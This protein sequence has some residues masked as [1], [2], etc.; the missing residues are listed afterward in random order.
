MALFGR[1]ESL[2]V[3]P[4]GIT[5]AYRTHG[6]PGHPAVL[7][8][9]GLG[10]QL[11]GWD[12]DLC[13]LFAG[14]GLF[15]I[16]FDNRDSG[17]S[18]HLHDAPP[19]D[20]LAAFGGDRSSAAYLL[21]D[22]ADDT[23]GLLD[24]LSLPAAHLIGVSMGGMI[25]QTVAALHPTRVRTL[26][27]IMANTGAPATSR[28]T[29]EAQRMLLRAPATTREGVIEGAVTSWRILG[30]PGYPQEEQLVRARAAR[31]YDRGLDARG[32]AR[33]LVAVLASGDRTA[34][35]STIR[36]P[37]LVV[38][39]AADPLVP[40]PGGLATAAAIPGAELLVL[41]GV[42]HDLPRPVWQS[43]IAGFLELLAREQA[44]VGG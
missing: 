21:T 40:L 28:S 24:A 27:S 5:L 6:R 10:A 12:D 34:Q 39:G 18:T 38:H 44:H 32:T 25:A 30:S 1:V 17:H 9:A 29:P 23:V 7:L 2:A 13:E 35:V 31:S 42:G 22:L 3:L 26:T 43:V 4:S 16:R 8:I 15:V 14:H 37:T 20:T 36:A 33:Q 19:P 11:V 41:P